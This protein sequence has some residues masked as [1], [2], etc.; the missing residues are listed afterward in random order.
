MAQQ[1]AAQKLA[2]EICADL[3]GAQYYKVKGILAERLAGTVG[4]ADAAARVADAILQDWSGAGYYKDPAILAE[5][6][7][8][9]G[10]AGDP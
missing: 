3:A 9:N 4:S 1:N 2:A 8:S 5:Y 10:V 6:L 7:H